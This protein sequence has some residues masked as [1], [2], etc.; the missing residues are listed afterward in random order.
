MLDRLAEARSRLLEQSHQAGMA[1]MAAGV[2]HNLR[3]GLAPCVGRLDGLAEK[4][5][6]LPGG[7]I[8]RAVEELAD[9]ATDETRRQRLLDYIAATAASFATAKEDA[10]AE[11]GAL[12]SHTRKLGE[13][14]KYQDQFI[15]SRSVVQPTGVHGAVLDAIGLLP[16]RVRAAVT[17]D[18]EPNVAQLPPVIAERIALI[19]IFHNLLLNAAEAIAAAG[20]AAGKVSVSGAVSPADPGT[21]DITVADNGTGIAPDQL[22]RVFARGYTTKPSGAG[23][24][25]LHWCANAAANMRC[26]LYATSAGV[27]QGAAFHLA[28]PAAEAR[29]AA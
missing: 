12:T 27:G 6:A 5:R 20:V 13:I 7:Q 18:V 19:Q 28:I 25:G 11:L 24:L 23:G 1:E 3:N 10:V 21:V 15:Y 8:G 17:I 16:Q 14:T 4:L 29:L 2:L 22:D 9:P 26:R